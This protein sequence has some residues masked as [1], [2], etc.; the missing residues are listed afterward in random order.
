MSGWGSSGSPIVI[1]SKAKQTA[2]QPRSKAPGVLTAP[3]GPPLVVGSSRDR[4]R[5]PHRPALPG[6]RADAPGRLERKFASLPKVLTESERATALAALDSSCVV[7]P[8]LIF[9]ILSCGRNPVMEWSIPLGCSFSLLGSPA[10]AGT[11]HP[12]MWSFPLG[13]SFLGWMCLD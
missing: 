13:S 8:A 3:A 5:S 9:Y 7:A 6:L 11:N 4:S 1:V 2:R 12:D 10:L